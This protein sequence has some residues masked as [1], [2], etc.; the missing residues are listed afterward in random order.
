MT[1]VETD[2]SRR[3]G[4]VM[5][6]KGWARADLVRISGQS[7]SLVSQWLGV[8]Q[9]PVYQINKAEAAERLSIASG[10]AALWI[11]KGLGPKM[12][13]AQSSSHPDASPLP[14]NILD[15]I[16]RLSREQYGDFLLRTAAAL[17]DV[18]STPQL[19]GETAN[20]AQPAPPRRNNA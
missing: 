4:E 6:A 19:G 11:A 3:L 8:S 2:L 20:T 16:N 13:E 14:K 1:R 15:R 18:E 12:R 5:Q 10:Y 7:S 17:A 9:R